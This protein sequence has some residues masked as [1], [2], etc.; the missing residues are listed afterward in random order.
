[1][2]DRRDSSAFLRFLALLTVLG[3][4]VPNAMVIAFLAS[5]GLDVTG[6]F[7]LWVD[8]LP[9]TQLTLDLVLVSATF[10]VWSVVDAR[11]NALRWWFVVPATCLVGICFAVPLYLL[12]RERARTARALT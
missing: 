1:M 8:S 4:V 9:A 5:N 12:I 3:F 6:Y 11:R 10:I 7:T 2:S